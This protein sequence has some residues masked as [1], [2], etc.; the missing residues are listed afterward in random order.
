[1]PGVQTGFGPD[2]ESDTTGTEVHPP[3]AVVGGLDA[4]DPDIDAETGDPLLTT[5]A[6]HPCGAGHPAI[7]VRDEV[8]ALRTGLPGKVILNVSTTAT[9]LRQAGENT[10]KQMTAL[11][12]LNAAFS[13][14]I[15]PDE[16]ERFDDFLCDS[17]PAIEFAELNEV[18]GR[19]VKRLAGGRPTPPVSG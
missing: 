11:S 16:A 13:R 6:D 15:H 9:K 3:P 14:L 5:D 18:L 10:E 17:N 8:F 1:M 2:P 4:L 7:E 19:M 12:H